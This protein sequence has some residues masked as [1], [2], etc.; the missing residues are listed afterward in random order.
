[1]EGRPEERSE[2]GFEHGQPPKH[3]GGFFGGPPHHHEE[4]EEQADTPLTRDEFKLYDKI[5]TFTMIS[6]LASL[7]LMCM[8]KGGMWASKCD[9]KWVSRCVMRKSCYM[10]AFFCLL[11][12]AMVHQG[13]G[14]KH[15]LRR[16]EEQAEQNETVSAAPCC[17]ANT[18]EPTS[19]RQL[20][21]HGMGHPPMEGGFPGG[22]PP[23]FGDHGFDFE[24]D[25]EPVQ[26]EFHHMHQFQFEEPEAETEE[27]VAEV[28]ET[29]T[30][31]EEPT[32]D[33]KRE[34]YKMFASKIFD[35]VYGENTP[36]ETTEEDEEPEHERH[37]RGSFM[38][39]HYRGQEEPEEDEHKP[40]HG[41][42]HCKKFKIVLFFFVS[43]IT[44]HFYHLYRLFKAREIHQALKDNQPVPTQ[45]TYPGQQYVDYASAQLQTTSDV[46]KQYMTY[47][48]RTVYPP[49]SAPQQQRTAP[50]QFVAAP[51]PQPPQ[52]V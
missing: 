21:G 5:K 13:K 48:Y 14:M 44:A 37:H 18:T 51:V 43:L 52:N 15:L 19:G 6:F 31:P 49:V 26:M 46:S 34:A 25:S 10:L 40:C 38:K 17:S 20:W 45:F 1:M 7:A 39:D 3:H 28:E 27:V 4:E 29:E 12:V 11:S 30:A 24:F 16:V 33:G 35:R 23:P 36:E 8:G 47:M 42:K 9:K 22:P 50:T 2:H 32:W 41:K